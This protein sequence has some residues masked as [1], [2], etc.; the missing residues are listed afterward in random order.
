[1][2]SASTPALTMSIAKNS[3]D[4]GEF[5]QQLS[6][7]NAADIATVSRKTDYPS[8]KTRKTCFYCGGSIHGR[9]FCPADHQ[10]CHQCG[11]FG[12]FAKVCRSTAKTSADVT[13]VAYAIGGGQY[14]V[15][16]SDGAPKCL[17]RIVV[18][19]LVNKHPAK[20]LLDTGASKNFISESSVEWLG[21]KYE[22]HYSNVTMASKEL[23]LAASGRAF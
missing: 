7:P 23:R 22:K 17:D 11:K 14:L 13:S 18:D 6:N 1:M 19:V 10:T 21:V 12:H 20:A 2:A 5:E 4:S 9:N 3:E 8:K 16:L 15:P